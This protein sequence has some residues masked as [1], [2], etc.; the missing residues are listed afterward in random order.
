VVNK[1]EHTLIEEQI[2]YYEE[3][4]AEYDDNLVGHNRY[5]ADTV[6]ERDNEVSLVIRALRDFK[7]RGD[8]IELAG[9]TG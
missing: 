9:G 1:N 8:V 6:V 3:R 2:R 4:A 7:A 5:D